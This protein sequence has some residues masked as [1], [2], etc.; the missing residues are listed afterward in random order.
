M[1]LKK[2]LLSK[3]AI[4]KTPAQ[5]V[6]ELTPRCNMNCKMCYIRMT[7][8]EMKPI[9]RELTAEEWIKI[10][11]DA[12][13]CGLLYLLFTGGEVFL[14]PDFEQIYS[15][16]YKNGTVISVNTN[17]TMLTEKNV[18]ML[19]DMPPE[20]VNLTLYGSSDEIYSRL[21]GNEHGYSRLMRSLEM[22]KQAG[23]RYMLN[24]SVTTQNIDDLDN[25]IRCANKNGCELNIATYMFP[26]VRKSDVCKRYDNIRL[27]P[28]AC[29]EVLARLN[30]RRSPDRMAAL[31]D[32]YENMTDSGE[33]EEIC[34]DTGMQCMASRAS[35]W[36]T[37]YGKMKA[38]AMFE[39]EYSLDDGFG[40]AW[41]KTAERGEQIRLPAEC[42]GCS[43]KKFCKSCAAVNL[44]EG[45]AYDSVPEF[46][47]KTADSY[48]ANT[49]KI[50]GK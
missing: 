10:Y 6:F 5:G 15:Y 28:E 21:C 19:H 36:I 26:P 32:A 17:G 25:M 38:C 27:T 44:A 47:C 11:D 12:D 2:S 13:R 3:A 4:T 29:G 50:L 46:M 24:C 7:E 9:G 8:E 20:H 18:Q 49:K 33:D 35:Y 22:L 34:P 45:G 31:Y 37:W 16:A 14:R 40:T 42:T 39:E 43:K 1:N 48:I 41:K 23:V 30:C